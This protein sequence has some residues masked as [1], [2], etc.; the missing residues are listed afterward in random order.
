MVVQQ[1]LVRLQIERREWQIAE[2]LCLKVS[3]S[4]LDITLVPHR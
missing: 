1:T 3:D 4:M 2:L